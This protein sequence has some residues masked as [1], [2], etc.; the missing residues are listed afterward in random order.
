MARASKIF[1]SA[2]AVLLLAALKLSTPA[3]AASAN[4]WR[5][6]AIYQVVTDRFYQGDGGNNSAC[7]NLSLYCGGTFD[8]I[9]EKLDYIQGMGFDAIWISPVVQSKHDT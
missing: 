3:M 6:R 4:D 7:E 1:A 2:A 5:G 8:G 9:S